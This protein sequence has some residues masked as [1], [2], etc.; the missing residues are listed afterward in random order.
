MVE[1]PPVAVLQVVEAIDEAC[2]QGLLHLESSRGPF[3]FNQ[4]GKNVAE[5]FYYPLAE[6]PG[7][8][9]ADF[10]NFSIVVSFCHI[11]IWKLK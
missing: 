4:A 2:K 8:A 10:E 6:L 1:D 11:K 3:I 7:V 9:R 5:V